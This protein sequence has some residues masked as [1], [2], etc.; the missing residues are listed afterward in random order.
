MGR[1]EESIIFFNKAIELDKNDGEAYYNIGVAYNN[2]GEKDDACTCW[3][4][5]AELNQKDGM[6][7]YQ[8]KCSKAGFT[9]KYSQK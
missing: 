7:M 5:A 2:M 9:K 6:S 3:K 8:S 4:K 1:Y